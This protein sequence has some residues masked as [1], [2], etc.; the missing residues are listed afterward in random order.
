MKRELGALLLLTAL[1]LSAVWNIRHADFLTDQIALNL[2]RTERAVAQGDFSLARTAADNA[3]TLWHR[4]RS[5]TG[6][7]LRHSDVDGVAD[8]F[9]DL[10]EMLLQKDY[11]TVKAGLSRLRY[12]LSMIDR[13]EH[14]SLGTIF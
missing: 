4:S 8:A 11:E 10:Q 14:L 3:L 6:V 12:H 9:Y 7:F 2:E 1:L 13:M 5:Y